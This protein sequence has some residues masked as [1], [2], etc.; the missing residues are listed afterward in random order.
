VLVYDG[1]CGLCTRL[2]ALAT[3][4]LD[5]DVDYQPYQTAELAALGVSEA[6]AAHSL[7]WVARS[8]RIGQG[9]AAVARLLVASGGLLALLGRVLLVPPVSWLAQLVYRLVAI[10][11]H[12]LPISPGPRP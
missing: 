3:S 4:R 11:R 7:L 8:G 12:H 5:A 1:S 10:L 2:V 6:E 9:S